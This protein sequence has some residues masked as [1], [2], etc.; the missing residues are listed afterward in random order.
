[1][2]SSSIATYTYFPRI[3]DANDVATQKSLN[4]YQQWTNTRVT[5]WE[6]ADW[7]RSSIIIQWR[8]IQIIR[9]VN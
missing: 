9:H 2:I 7:K 3:S 4:L 6:I 5:P 1:M 8:K